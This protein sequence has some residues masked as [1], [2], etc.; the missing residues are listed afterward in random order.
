M[1]EA[2]PESYAEPVIPDDVVAVPMEDAVAG[3]DDENG[4]SDNT[5]PA[6]TPLPQVGRPLGIALGAALLLLIVVFLWLL[7]VWPFS[8]TGPAEKMTDLGRLFLFGSIVAVVWSAV[9]S[10]VA[11]LWPRPAPAAGAGAFALPDLGTFLTAVGKG[12]KWIALAVIGVGLIIFG[13][14]LD[15]YRFADGGFTATPAVHQTAPTPTTESSS[16]S[17]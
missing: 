8:D 7:D 6:T 2:V 4:H 1:G 13:M 3:K 10:A 16:T 17:G 9:I 5:T 14:M 11:T 12:P 15:G